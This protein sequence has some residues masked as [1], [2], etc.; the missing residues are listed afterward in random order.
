[1]AS[2]RKRKARLNKKALFAD[3]GYEPHPG[4][5]EIHSSVSFR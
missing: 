4:Q 2:K 3:L 5:L 1:M